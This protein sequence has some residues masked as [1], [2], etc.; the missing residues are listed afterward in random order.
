[1][2]A[3][4]KRLYKSEPWGSI[5]A[6]AN[7]PWNFYGFIKIVLQFLTPL[8]YQRCCCIYN[9]NY[10]TAINEADKLPTNFFLGILGNSCLSNCL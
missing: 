6:A 5:T 3:E 7:V 2:G 9:T 4:S 10:T 8:F 1:M